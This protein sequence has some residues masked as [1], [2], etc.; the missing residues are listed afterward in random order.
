MSRHLIYTSH[1]TRL[2][3]ATVLAVAVAGCA[4]PTAPSEARAVAVV[5]PTL[6]PAL[7][8]LDGIPTPLPFNG[9]TVAA[10]R[11]RLDVPIRTAALDRDYGAVWTGSEILVNSGLTGYDT[12][13]VAGLIAHELRHADGIAHDCG[14]HQDHR[15][16]PWSAYAVHVWTLDQ[17]GAH[18][19]ARGNEGGFCD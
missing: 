11:Q 3:A 17:L 2:L 7:A 19:Q 15:A 16:T 12:A 6:A 9:L 8:L 13:G 18:D 10:W 1:M 14:P 4:A 5:D